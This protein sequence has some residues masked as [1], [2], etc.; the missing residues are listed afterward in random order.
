M[1]FV[2]VGSQKFSFD[3]LLTK[4]DQMAGEHILTEEVYMQTGNSTFE[5]KNCHYQQFYDRDKFAEMVEKCSILITHGGV[6][7][8]V[9]A[10]KRGKKVI[11][12]PR[13]AELGE[14]V[15]GHQQQLMEQFH[16]RNLISACMN[17]DDLPYLLRMANTRKFGGYQS[18]TE[19]FV[20]SVDEFLQSL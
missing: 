12:V 3:R 10:V 16:A 8:V 14:H 6:G 15:D 2:T 18:N 7:I 11:V 5:P 19:Q 17:V 1:I 20:A 4:V 13:R 9:D